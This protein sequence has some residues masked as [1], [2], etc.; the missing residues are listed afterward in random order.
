MTPIT[1][2]RM[3][4]V[5]T[6]VALLTA[7]TAPAA[8][9]ATAP[10]GYADVELYQTAAPGGFVVPLQVSCPTGTV[11]WG[12]G[13]GDL[14][15]I[16]GETL[17]GSFAYGSTAWFGQYNNSSTLSRTFQ[18]D[19]LCANRPKGYAQKHKTV[20]NPSGTLTAA[21]V[22]CPAG[23]VVLGGGAQ[24]TADAPGS[25]IENTW[26]KTK[27]AFAA[28]N[29]NLTGNDEKLTVV[30]VCA[31]QP[32]GYTRATQVVSATGAGGYYTE[33]RCP[34]GTSIIGGGVHITP[35]AQGVTIGASTNRGTAAWEGRV[36]VTSPATL[37]ITTKAICAS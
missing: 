14:T 26:P 25:F 19:A 34:A 11:V 28:S 35:I 10:P 3:S 2:R 31:K 27:T 7:A 17:A 22:A 32:A 18:A 20:D 12:G 33:A 21:S 5:A 36:I 16:I 8:L 4:V 29:L 24:T 15:P 37:T 23:T 1:A 9:A 6:L 13:A 30:A